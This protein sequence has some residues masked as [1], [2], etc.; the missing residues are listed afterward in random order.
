MCVRGLLVCQGDACVPGAC[1]CA[2]GMHVCQGD[3]C[4]PGQCMC[5]RGMHVCQGDACVPGGCMCR[6]MG[7]GG[8]GSHLLSPAAFPKVSSLATPG[9]WGHFLLRISH[10]FAPPN[11]PS[12]QRQ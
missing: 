6:P 3:A 8:R 12:I 1:K 4:V 2:R 7:G 9:G 5:A 10:L 11:T